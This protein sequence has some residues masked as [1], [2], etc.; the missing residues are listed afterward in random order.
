MTMLDRPAEPDSGR[1]R[2][3]LSAVSCRRCPW[4][5]ATAP[6]GVAELAALRRRYGFRVDGSLSPQDAD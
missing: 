1:E 6:S 4:S 2:G 3:V 5:Q